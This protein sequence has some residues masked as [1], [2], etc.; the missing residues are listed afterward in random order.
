VQ[1]FNQL[2]TPVEIIDEIFGGRDKYLEALR[3]LERELY[4]V[5]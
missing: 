4:K 3:G 1:P 5:A 2:G